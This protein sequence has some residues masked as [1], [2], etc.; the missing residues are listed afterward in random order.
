MTEMVKLNRKFHD[1][2]PEEQLIWRNMDYSLRR[3]Y[4]WWM[5]CAYDLKFIPMW[6]KKEFLELKSIMKHCGLET[7]QCIK[8]MPSRKYIT[9]EILV[10]MRWFPFEPLLI[11]LMDH[12]WGVQVPW[13]VYARLTMAQRLRD[14]L[15]IFREPMDIIKDDLLKFQLKGGSRALQRRLRDNCK[16]MSIEYPELH[17]VQNMARMVGSMMDDSQK[18]S[19]LRPFHFLRLLVGEQAEENGQPFFIMAHYQIEKQNQKMA[20]LNLLHSEMDQ[21]TIDSLL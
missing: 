7:Q 3:R 20:L 10:Y 8:R 11:A 9:P 12:A 4:W 18:M 19:L 17:W 13:Q 21:E 14:N 5:D 2:P 6:N 1:L 16:Q 15:H